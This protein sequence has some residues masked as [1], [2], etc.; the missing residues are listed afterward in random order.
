M[1][2]Y[3][4]K[5]IE[6][7]HEQAIEKLT[8]ALKEEGFGVL[9]HIDIHSKLYEKLGVGFRKYSILG[10]CSPKHAYQALQ[11]EDK[12]GTMLPCNVIVQQLENGMVEIA[13]VNPVASMMAIDNPELIKVA[14]E[15]K[16][17]SPVLLNRLN[18][19]H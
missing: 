5:K 2:Y 7:S 18:K 3:I 10:A 16:R 12:V 9:S 13:A 17:N 11:K 4:S 19:F 15:K 8:E 1:S 6:S 14:E